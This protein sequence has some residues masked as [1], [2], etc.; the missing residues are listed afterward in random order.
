VVLNRSVTSQGEASRWV[1]LL[2]GLITLLLVSSS[3]SVRVLLL[4]VC[5]AGWLP[6]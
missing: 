1:D 5:G 6:R 3:L 2:P 4:R